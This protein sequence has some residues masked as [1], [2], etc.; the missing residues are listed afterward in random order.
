MKTTKHAFVAILSVGIA[1]SGYSQAVVGARTA[2]SAAVKANVN[3]HAAQR[4]VTATSSATKATVQHAGKATTKT[5]TTAQNTTA[6][7]VKANAKLRNP[8]N[9]IVQPPR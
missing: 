7:K 3:S 2:T 1:I 8:R 5:A 6:T 4:A 9:K